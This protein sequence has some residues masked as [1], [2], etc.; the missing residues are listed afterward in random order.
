MRLW[1]C[2]L[3]LETPHKFLLLPS[4]WPPFLPSLPLST[5]L[6]ST[7]CVS[8]TFASVS[9]ETRLCYDRGS[10]GEVHSLTRENVSD[11]THS[12]IRMR[13]SPRASQMDSRRATGHVCT[14]LRMQHCVIWHRPRGLPAS[15]LDPATE[16][17]QLASSQPN[18]RPIS[19]SGAT[20]FFCEENKRGKVLEKMRDYC[21]WTTKLQTACTHYNKTL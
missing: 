7:C 19:S 21:A 14:A 16:R 12:A 20:S 15:W 18:H 10:T 4:P 9:T 13:A 5:T 2:G 17:W 6:W 3:L 8:P 11:P 1:P